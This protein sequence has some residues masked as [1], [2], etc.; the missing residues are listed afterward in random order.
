MRRGILAA[1]AAAMAVAGCGTDVNPGTA[2]TPITR[3]ASAA[4]PSAGLPPATGKWA[5]LT[6][7]CPD[8]TSS[9]AAQLGLSGA[10]RPTGEYG[11]F[12]DIVR[13]DC[14]WSSTGDQRYAAIVRVSIYQRQ[15]AADAEWQALRT[16]QTRP[17][18]GLGREAFAAVQPGGMTVRVLS[19]N[20]VATVRLRPL[21]SSTAPES[22][23]QLRDPTIAI[24][25]NVLDDLR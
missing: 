3:S 20:A 21:A 9:E 10:G 25:K 17:V 7:K 1:A 14:A 13:A 5:G 19:N 12:G 2:E 18:P 24:A 11:D 23:E 8:L 4:A 22:L 6:A 15:E 16:G